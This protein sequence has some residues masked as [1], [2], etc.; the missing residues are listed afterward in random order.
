MGSTKILK[1]TILGVCKVHFVPRPRQTL[2]SPRRCHPLCWFCSWPNT[3]LWRTWADLSQT[4]KT[5]GQTRHLGYRSDSIQRHNRYHPKQIWVWNRSVLAWT[6]TDKQT[7][8]L[9]CIQTG[10]CPQA[11]KQTD[12]QTDATKRIIS[13]AL[14]SIKM[15]HDMR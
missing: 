7:E 13:P 14:R 4:R 9:G 10:E 6:I 8:I 15:L 2:K 1:W 12:G 5:I 3:D 11:N